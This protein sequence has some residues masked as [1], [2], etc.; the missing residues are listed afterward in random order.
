AEK[1]ATI[2]LFGFDQWQSR[3]SGIKKSELTPEALQAIDALVLPV[4]GADEHGVV[5]SIF[6]AQELRLEDDHISSLPPKAKIYTGIAKKFLRELCAKHHV[7]LVELLDRDDVAIYNSIPTAEGAV[8]MAIQNTDVTI[9]G[10]ECM[11]LGLGR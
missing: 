9:H 7:E 10:S 6:S 3:M 2:T 5:E 11:V 4:A 1:D 8:M